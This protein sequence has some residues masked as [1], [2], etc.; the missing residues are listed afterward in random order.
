[1]WFGYKEDNN[2][3]PLRID[4]V[5][6]I[7]AMNRA[8]KKPAS[9]EID[10]EEVKEPISK[11]NR[12]LESLDRKFQSKSKKKKKNRNRGKDRPTPKSTWQKSTSTK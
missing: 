9:L 3:Y 6:E 1:M 10:E 8:G 7:L 4:R 2:W 12:D 11:L 5:N